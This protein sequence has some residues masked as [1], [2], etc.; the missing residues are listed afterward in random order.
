M[1]VE[2]RWTEI[3]TG[4]QKGYYEDLQNTV[5]KEDEMLFKLKDNKS[6]YSNGYTPHPT[7]G[8]ESE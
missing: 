6:A 2:E 5:S 8:G 7:A 4:A 1:C 3:G